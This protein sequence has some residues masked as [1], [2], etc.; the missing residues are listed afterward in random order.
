MKQ[1]KIDNLKAGVIRR[2]RSDSFY[3]PLEYY[4]QYL[5]CVLS[6][7]KKLDELTDFKIHAAVLDMV[8]ENI[9]L[10]DIRCMHSFLREFDRWLPAGLNANTFNGVDLVEDDWVV[11]W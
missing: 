4:H 6:A 3:M 11:F 5:L 10:W 2:F 1:I 9:R 7:S 8:C